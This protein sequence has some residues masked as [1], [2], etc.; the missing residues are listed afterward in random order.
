VATRLTA[1]RNLVHDAKVKA[2]IDALKRLEKQKPPLPPLLR[3]DK[4]KLIH[5]HV[6]TAKNNELAVRSKP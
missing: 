6:T 4:Q 2:L 1:T 5:A 3:V